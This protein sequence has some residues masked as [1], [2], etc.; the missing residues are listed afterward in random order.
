MAFQLRKG[1]SAGMVSALVLAACAR[2]PDAGSG[3]KAA[4]EPA[5]ATAA[6]PLAGAPA[7]DRASVEL[8]RVV[9]KASLEL[10]VAVPGDAL[11]A[12]TRL[13]EREGGFVASTERS[14]LAEAGAPTEGSITL[15]LRVPAQRFSALLEALRKLGK[16]AGSES[17]T[18][19][20]V[21]EEFID[22]EARIKNQRELEAQFLQILKQ[23]S[24]VEEALNVQ[25]EVSG[26]RTEIDRM[27]GRRRFLERETA[28]STVT[29]RLVGERPLVRASLGDFTG[30]VVRASSDTVNLSAGI[31]TSVIRTLGVLLPLALLLGAPLLLLVRVGLRRIRR[32]LPVEVREG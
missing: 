7:A 4:P 15:V 23:A 26:V 3:S 12:A 1:V 32:A 29:L 9:K 5:V 6:A 16:G 22:L 8:R 27:E 18:T 13:V 25:R 14:A 11:A 10:E 21:S 17:I 30:A 2:A 24:K 28:L 20:D 31:V 19:E